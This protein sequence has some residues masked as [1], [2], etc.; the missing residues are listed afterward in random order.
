MY[1]EAQFQLP[2]TRE[3]AEPYFTVGL[4]GA[5]LYTKPPGPRLPLHRKIYLDS[6]IRAIFGLPGKPVPKIM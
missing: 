3:K 5:P 6:T 2:Y 1:T 4:S